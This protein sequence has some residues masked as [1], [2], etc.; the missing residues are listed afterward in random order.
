MNLRIIVYRS[1]VDVRQ[2]FAIRSGVFS[3]EDPEK[4][5]DTWS[6][7]FISL[8]GMSRSIA[9]LFFFKL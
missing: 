1:P 9:V 6:S 2:G 5:I 3:L 8:F 4:Y 7:Y